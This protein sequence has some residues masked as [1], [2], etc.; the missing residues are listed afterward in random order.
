MLD[1]IDKKII[2]ELDLNSRQSISTL[3]RKLRIGKNVALYR[4]NN[5]KKSGII[6]KSFAELNS[7]AL[8]Y[9]TFRI[10][11]KTGNYNKNEEENLINFILSNKNIT[12]FSRVI[13]KWDFD[14]WYMCKD[15]SEF[16]DFRKNFLENFNSIIEE[17]EISLL[18]QIYRYP[19]D[20]ILD[21]KRERFKTEIFSI[22]S[23]RTEIDE[24]DGK[25]L[26][27]LSNDSSIT[28]VALSKQLKLSIN[29]IKKKLKNLE[30]TGVIQG[31]HLF[32]DPL[33]LGYEYYK[34]HVYLKDYHE[35]DI[36]KLR[37][38]L[39]G[40]NFVIYTDHYINGADFEIELNLKNEKEYINFIQ[41]LG[42]NFGNI[43]KEK[44]LIKF[45]ET[46]IFKY[47]PG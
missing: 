37:N 11:I 23:P 20:F 25:I 41:E 43:I 27:I 18:T 45:Y 42:E 12:W 30:K 38:W 13:G 34:L 17:N 8:G 9:L 26:R 33:K 24:K 47:L 19:K 46:K 5:L 15:I 36:S 35:T 31:Y 6:K 1:L 29:T 10:F 4:I 39:E 22:K 21:R 14:I 40:K 3:A 7:F 28:L 16:E 32:L 44:F 2:Y